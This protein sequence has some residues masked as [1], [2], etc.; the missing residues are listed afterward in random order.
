M[1]LWESRSEIPFRCR[2]TQSPAPN[3]VPGCGDSSV[4]PLSLNA[5]RLQVS[6]H[7]P[8]FSAIPLIFPNAAAELAVQPSK[9]SKPTSSAGEYFRRRIG[10]S[11]PIPLPSPNVGR[12]FA[13][14]PSPPSGTPFVP[15]DPRSSATVQGTAK[16]KR[17][18]EDSSQRP[19]AVCHPSLTPPQPVSGT[20]VRDEPFHPGS[21]RRALAKT[22]HIHE[23]GRHRRANSSRGR[24]SPGTLETSGSPSRTTHTIDSNEENEPRRRSVFNAAKTPTGTPRRSGSQPRTRGSSGLRGIH[25]PSASASPFAHLNR[26]PPRCAKPIGLQKHAENFHESASGSDLWED[27]SDA[28]DGDD[29]E[30]LAEALFNPKSPDPNEALRSA[31]N[32]PKSSPGQPRRPLKFNAEQPSWSP[33]CSPGTATRN[34]YVS[35]ARGAHLPVAL[36][37]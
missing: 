4:P 36:Q 21:I 14:V 11:T 23:V 1:P 37:S 12:R 6:L 22:A 24:Q 19:H 29:E 8:I 16:G 35:E 32:L 25:S 15:N 7:S 5:P 27:T 31:E 33:T 30:A 18:L 13:N 26:S 20:P 17:P 9:S 3:A 28:A 10:P 34:V 2:T